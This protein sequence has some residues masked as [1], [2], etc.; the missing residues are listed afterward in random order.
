MGEPKDPGSGN[1]YNPLPPFS[2]SSP[3]VLMNENLSKLS[4]LNKDLTS[5]ERVVEKAAPELDTLTENITATYQ[6]I[7]D[8]FAEE[9]KKRRVMTESFAALSNMLKDCKSKLTD[10]QRDEVEDMSVFTGRISE[11]EQQLTQTQ[12]R[13]NDQIGT[14]RA[15]LNKCQRKSETLDDELDKKT[16]ECED[17]RRTVEKLDSRRKVLAQANEDLALLN[18]QYTS[19]IQKQSGLYQRINDGLRKVVSRLQGLVKGTERGT[20]MLMEYVPDTL[21]S[22]IRDDVMKG[23]DFEFIDKSVNL[24]NTIKHTMSIVQKKWITNNVLKTMADLENVTQTLEDY[25]SPST[26]KSLPIWEQYWEKL[27]EFVETWVRKERDLVQ[28][29]VIS[30]NTGL[31]P[32]SRK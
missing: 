20:P 1:Q 28:K 15:Q 13:L 2:S 24:E 26:A 6:G 22:E 32:T 16:T 9:S 25:G 31:T 19:E 18:G 17:L 29:W 7:S 12:Q 11:L 5:Q 30:R 14:L 10:E 21:L 4:G 23:G 8:E 3:T 27:K